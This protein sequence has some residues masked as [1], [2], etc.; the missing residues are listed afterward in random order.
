MSNKDD[1][2]L[3]VVATDKLEKLF[4]V[5]RGRGGALRP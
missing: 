3:S 4:Y 2:M 1:K 5:L